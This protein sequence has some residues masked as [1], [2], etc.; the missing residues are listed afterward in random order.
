[1][2]AHCRSLEDCGSLEW[3][4]ADNAVITRHL[5][6]EMGEIFTEKVDDIFR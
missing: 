2:V 3:T 4:E 5:F 6:K 1:M